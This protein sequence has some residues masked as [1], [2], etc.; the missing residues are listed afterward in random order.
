M[1]EALYND[2]TAYLTDTWAGQRFDEQPIEFSWGNVCKLDFK[3]EIP[4]ATPSIAKAKAEGK[5][6]AMRVEATCPVHG[7]VKV[8]IDFPP[9]GREEHCPCCENEEKRR[10]DSLRFRRQIE[11]KKEQSKQ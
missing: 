8:F 7:T 6:T 10:I 2:L 1:A 11:R 9:R 5:I 4:I 3:E